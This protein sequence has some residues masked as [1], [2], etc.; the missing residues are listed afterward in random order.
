MPSES[1]YCF[2]T[3]PH[4]HTPTGDGNAHKHLPLPPPTHTHVRAE[5]PS[6]RNT[7]YLFRLAEALREMGVDD[8]HVFGLEARVKSIL[9]GGEA[10][11]GTE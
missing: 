1:H 7:E 5:G 8:G 3:P 6:G 4:T 2:R 10:A 11:E 9:A